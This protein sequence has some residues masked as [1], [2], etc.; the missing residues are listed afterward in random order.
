MKIYSFL[1]LFIGLFF[2]LLLAAQD[3]TNIKAEDSPDFFTRQKLRYGLAWINGWSSIIGSNLPADYFYKPS[4]GLRFQADYYFNQN[5]GLNVGIAYQQRGAGILTPDY[6]KEVGNGDSTYRLRLRFNS[7]ELPVLLLWR[8]AQPTI[9]GTRF[10]VGLGAVPALIARSGTIFNSVED[11]FHILE[12]V[13]P[14][15]KRFDM[16]AQA[17]FGLD[18]NASEACLLQVQLF[19]QQ[20]F[21]NAYKSSAFANAKGYSSNWGIKLAF[22]F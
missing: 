1:S 7:F 19:Y 16:L 20:G 4:V 9:G 10:T 13:S 15:Y 3:K 22:M 12:N 17:Q 21:I 11:G 6:V 18:I 5:W 8:Q 14:Q 2:P